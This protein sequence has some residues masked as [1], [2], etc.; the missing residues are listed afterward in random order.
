MI[1]LSEHIEELKD[2]LIE[3]V[4]K[5]AEASFVRSQNT[6]ACYVPFQTGKLKNSGSFIKEEKGGTITYEAPY[7]SIQ[8]VGQEGGDPIV[9]VQ[10]VRVSAHVRKNKRGGMEIVPAHTKKYVNKR[11]ICFRPK[12]SKF[13]YEEPICR[14]IKEEPHID[15][16]FY[17]SRAVYDTFNEDFVE[18]LRGVMNTKW[19]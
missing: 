16:Q 7:A 14:V 6:Q 17:V 15:G 10:E 11:L 18:I 2:R 19:S 4:Q 13:Q 8:E 9:G 12:V 3:V 5:T 1:I